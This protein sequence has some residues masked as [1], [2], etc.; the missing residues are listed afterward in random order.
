M[1]G[2]IVGS[3]GTVG[4]RQDE[5]QKDWLRKQSGITIPDDPMMPAVIA[6]EDTFLSDD[7]QRDIFNNRDK[8]KRKEKPPQAPDETPQGNTLLSQMAAAEEQSQMEDKKKKGRRKSRRSTLLTS[9]SEDQ[10][11]GSNLGSGIGKKKLGS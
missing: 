10:T 4:R 3:P 7:T 5:K 11:T 6:V 2:G 8:N 1:C 9:E